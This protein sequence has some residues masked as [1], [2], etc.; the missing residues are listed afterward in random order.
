MHNC[1]MLSNI[2]TVLGVNVG[3]AHNRCLGVLGA[4][5][6]DAGNANSTKI[7]DKVCWWARAVPT[8][9][10]TPTRKPSW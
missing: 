8:T 1:K 7:S 4:G 5:Q 2:E 9:S 3:G 10:P 6:I